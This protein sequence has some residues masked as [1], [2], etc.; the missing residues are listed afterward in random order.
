MRAK[1]ITLF[2]ICSVVVDVSAVGT[3][4]YIFAKGR[5]WHG[6]L[7]HFMWRCWENFLSLESAS[8]HGII[9]GLLVAVLE[10]LAIFGILSFLGGAAEMKERIGAGAISVAVLVILVALVYGTQFAWEAANTTYE[11]HRSLRQANISLRN[12]NQALT[13]ANAQLVNPSGIPIETVSIPL[14]PMTV[15]SKPTEYRVMLTNGNQGYVY[16]VIGITRNKIVPLDAVLSC[17][18]DMFVM[19]GAVY[20]GGVPV[21]GHQQPFVPT[22]PNVTAESYYKNGRI[23]AEQPAWTVTHPLSLEIVSTS[24]T[25]NC[26]IQESGH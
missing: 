20:I 23:R 14:R 10:M 2:I 9:S 21:I 13:I 1:L 18:H 17:D 15:G 22:D 25:L 5:E 3:A 6:G 8:G 26:R 19:G 7:V 11:G 4:V 24:P 12:K 16:E